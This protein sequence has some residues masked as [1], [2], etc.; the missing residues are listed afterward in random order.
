M[1]SAAALG[2]RSE[3]IFHRADGEVIDCRAE[4]GC[5]VIR[6]PSNPTYYWGNYLLF[7]RAPET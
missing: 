6:T 4:H 5:R 7:E 3:L 1:A 2:F